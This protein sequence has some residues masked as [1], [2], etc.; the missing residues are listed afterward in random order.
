MLLGIPFWT[1]HNPACYLHKKKDPRNI[2][3]PSALFSQSTVH[4]GPE[5][6]PIPALS[7]LPPFP[8][9][10]KNNDKKQ[11]KFRR[12][13]PPANY[14]DRPSDRRLSAKLVPT[15]ADRGCRVVGAT[16]PHGC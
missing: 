11:K 2:K 14:T 3:G 10:F 8:D 16:N 7:L 4:T 9:A 1:S 6:A 5:E 13:S 12:F 15:L